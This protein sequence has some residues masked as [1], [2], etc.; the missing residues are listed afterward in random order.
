MEKQ[1]EREDRTGSEDTIT[2]TIVTTGGMTRRI[3]IRKS[4]YRLIETLRTAG[5][6]TKGYAFLKDGKTLKTNR[7][8]EL[9]EDPLLDAD[10]TIT[11]TEER[12]TGGPGA[13][14]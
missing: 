6:K 3:V 8:G 4:K 5:Y 9:V 2:V 12:L 14:S 1:K 13:L 7:E 10:T 11:I